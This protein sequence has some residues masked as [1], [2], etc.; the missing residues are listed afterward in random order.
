MKQSLAV[1]V[2]VLSVGLGGCANLGT[3]T[4]VG[5]SD[6]VLKLAAKELAAVRKT[7]HVWLLFDQATGNKTVT[8]GK[9]YAT[10]R[11]AQDRGDEELA[12]RLARKVI[13]AARAGQKQA[14]DVATTADYYINY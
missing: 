5:K 7:G 11:A 6:Q 10:A 12:L 4:T 3:G 14:Q 13:W 8:V 2:T 1:L 9:L